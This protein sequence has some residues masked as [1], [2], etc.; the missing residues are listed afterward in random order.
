MADDII[1]FQEG[2]EAA[3]AGK[4]CDKRRSADWQEGWRQVMN[5]GK[6]DG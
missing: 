6:C 1:Q 4:P 2:R 3:I 5:E